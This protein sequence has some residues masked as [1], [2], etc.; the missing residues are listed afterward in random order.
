MLVKPE[1]VEVFPRVPG[2]PAREARTVCPYVPPVP[3]VPP[4]TPP[5]SG[6]PTSCG[7][8]IGVYRDVYGRLCVATQYCERRCT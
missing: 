1:H 6:D 5:P 8:I 4:S 7:F 3:Y 2:V